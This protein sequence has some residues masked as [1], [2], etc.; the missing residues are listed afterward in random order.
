[1]AQLIQRHIE[2]AS[3][4]LRLTSKFNFTENLKQ[5]WHPDI[6]PVSL[7]LLCRC[8]WAWT[9]GAHYPWAEAVKSNLVGPA[10]TGGIRATH[11]LGAALSKWSWVHRWWRVGH[12][13]KRLHFHYLAVVSSFWYVPIG[14]A[15]WVPRVYRLFQNFQDV[16]WVPRL[17]LK[18]FSPGRHDE[19]VRLFFTSSLFLTMTK[20]CN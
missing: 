15:P 20:P 18:W 5:L 13:D 16:G 4:C 12:D 8:I 19:E 10:D 7:D 17:L 11:P 2:P 3:R 1:M 6:Q 14:A 9:V